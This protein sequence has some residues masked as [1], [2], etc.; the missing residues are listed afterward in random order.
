MMAPGLR[1]RVEGLVPLLRLL[2]LQLAWM[3]NMIQHYCEKTT[4]VHNLYEEKSVFHVYVNM[5]K[6]AVIADT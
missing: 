2:V 6:L 3:K 1:E 5:H 4:P